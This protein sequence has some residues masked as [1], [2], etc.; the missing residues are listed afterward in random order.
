MSR[1]L[2]SESVDAIDLSDL[3]TET[4]VV[5]GRPAALTAPSS[6]HNKNVLRKFVSSVSGGGGLLKRS[7]SFERS[8]SVDVDSWMANGDVHQPHTTSP[9]PL[10][11]SPESSSVIIQGTHKPLPPLPRHA[12]EQ[13]LNI[14]RKGVSQPK[15]PPP[16]PPPRKVAE[17][18][19]QE[20]VSMGAFILSKSV[21]L[22]PRNSRKIPDSPPPHPAS[23]SDYRKSRIISSKSQE[24]FRRDRVSPST[25]LGLN[26][27]VPAK[28]FAALPR[29]C[30]S[31]D[32]VTIEHLRRRPTMQKSISFKRPDSA[33][34]KIQTRVSNATF[35]QFEST[36]LQQRQRRERGGH[37]SQLWFLDYNPDRARDLTDDPKLRPTIT[38]K[39]KMVRRTISAP[40]ILY[41]KPI[42]S[43]RVASSSQAVWK[44]LDKDETSSIFGAQRMLGR[45]RTEDSQRE[46]RDIVFD[47]VEQE[48]V[49]MG[50]TV[51]RLIDKMINSL[52]QDVNYVLDFLYSFPTF[53]TPILLL[54]KLFKYCEATGEDRN[55]ASRRQ[56][57]YKI[58]DLWF[59][60]C[61]SDFDDE[62]TLKKLTRF[63][64]KVSV[65]NSD[66]SI[67]LQ[68]QLQR[69][70]KRRVFPVDFSSPIPLVE[71]TLSRPDQLPGKAIKAK[72]DLRRTNTITPGSQD[73]YH[74]CVSGYEVINWCADTLELKNRL[75]A[76]NYGQVLLDTGI[77]C[78]QSKK[79][80]VQFEDG[81]RLYKMSD[82]WMPPL[83]PILIKKNTEGADF[84]ELDPI[85]MT[86]F[87]ESLFYD[88]TP[89]QMLRYPWTTANKNSAKSVQVD[90]ILERFSWNSLWVVN[91]VM[92]SSTISQRRD[93]ISRF[94]E[95]AEFCFRIKNFGDC[96]AIL[97]GLNNRLVQK[98]KKAWAAISEKSQRDLVGLEL[99]SPAYQSTMRKDHQQ[100]APLIPYFGFFV[101]DIIRLDEVPDQIGGHL[102]NFAKKRIYS[103]IL[104]QLNGYK[105]KRFMLHPVPAYSQWLKSIKLEPE[106]KLQERLPEAMESP[107]FGSPPSSPGR[108]LE[109]YKS[110]DSLK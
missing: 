86:L 67:L 99:H 87:S 65:W 29:A 2:R 5:T 76:R 27:Q 103:N 16:L 73:E 104:K 88:L 78:I 68:S 95:I 98:Q 46:N 13:V 58:L 57:V 7:F 23:I 42:K 83:P 30:L 71:A 21:D 64:T 1:W 24:N 8:R 91:E 75:Q 102:I 12:T 39:M 22:P 82:D 54:E 32:D 97:A 6:F 52:I 61:C 36:A 49:V 62:E 31:A 70:Y 69:H 33:H 72:F 74:R 89:R 93:V 55:V 53:I 26:S 18:S 41:K 28:L 40:A 14:P 79:T 37:G 94:I 63:I 101:A 96:M 110:T 51:D 105:K 11:R 4:T 3:D 59:I 84:L 35:R 107:R 43:N 56:R 38:E 45:H 60:H 15:K 44:Q 66:H 34:P 92:K 19:N 10:R 25:T 100:A 106:E 85:E 108:T 48:K 81:E 47:I 90:L 77:L 80:I 20:D 109:L 9:V 50:G 17:N